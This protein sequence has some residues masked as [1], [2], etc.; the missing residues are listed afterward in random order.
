[1]FVRGEQ[2]ECL[3]LLQFFNF[4]NGFIFFLHA[5]DGHK[6]V[7]PDRLGHEDF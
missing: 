5:L 6:L 2:L 4:F 3:D 1:M 7:V